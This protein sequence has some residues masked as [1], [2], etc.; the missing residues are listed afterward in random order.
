MARRRKKKGTIAG[1]MSA[2]RAEL[3]IV[4]K[5]QAL[6]AAEVA[7]LFLDRSTRRNLNRSGTSTGALARS[8]EAT[9]LEDQ[10]GVLVGAGAFSDLPYAFIHETGG[11]IRPKR[12]KALAV[13]LTP[14]A[15]KAGSPRNMPNLS[16]MPRGKFPPLLIDYQGFKTHFVLPKKVFIPGTG[17]ITEAAEKAAPV[18]MDIIGRGVFSVMSSAA[19]KTL[20]F[21]K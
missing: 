17:Y 12:A 5:S 19:G 8:W 14:E 11:V 21:E 18:M 15:R 1:F 7:A 6:E 16:F 10:S 2:I 3:P 20:K 13:P 9:I 4:M